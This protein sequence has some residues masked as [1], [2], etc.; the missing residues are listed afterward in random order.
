MPSWSPFFKENNYS[1]NN[2]YTLRTSGEGILICLRIFNRERER[3]SSLSPLERSLDHQRTRKE[4]SSDHQRIRESLHLESHHHSSPKLF[5]ILDTC[6]DKSLLSLVE[7]N[8]M[9]TI[10]FREFSCCSSFQV[11]H[12]KIN[13][14]F[15]H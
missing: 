2:N 9:I 6:T 13:S 10:L 1:S 8:Q 12:M 15:H 14:D 7:V 4:K 3:N 11:K 5:V